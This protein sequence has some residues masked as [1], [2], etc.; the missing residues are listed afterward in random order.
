M[1]DQNRLTKG[2]LV[3]KHPLMFIVASWKL[4]SE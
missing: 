2:M 1:F 4:Y 3:G